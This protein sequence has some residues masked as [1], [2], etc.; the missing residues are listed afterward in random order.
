MKVVIATLG[1]EV[2]WRGAVTV[3]QMLREFGVGVVYIGNAFPE[4][5]IE[6]AIREDVIAV[7]VSSLSGGHLVLGSDLIHLAHKKNIKDKVVFVIG[8]VF[9]PGDYDELMKLGFD[10]VFGSDAT[11]EDIYNFLKKGVNAKLDGS[12]GNSIA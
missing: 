5:I 2:H 10:G 7:G 9:P 1:L 4:E 11:G 3:A 6:A 8:G 12:A